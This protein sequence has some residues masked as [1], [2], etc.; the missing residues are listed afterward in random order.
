MFQPHRNTIIA[1]VIA[2]A[3]PYNIEDGKSP[4]TAI[5]MKAEP[6]KPIKTRSPRV[7]LIGRNPFRLTVGLMISKRV[8]RHKPIAIDIKKIAVGW[9]QAIQVKRASP[10]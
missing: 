1:H 3:D 10:M 5:W 7:V 4:M 2:V 9:V 6:N 8:N